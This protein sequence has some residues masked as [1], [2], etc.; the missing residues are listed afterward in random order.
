[1]VRL[2]ILA[3][4]AGSNARNILQHF[5]ESE[6]VQV[7]LIATNNPNAGVLDIAKE[8]GVESV[9]FDKKTF[10]ESDS[11]LH[12]LKESKVDFVVL[13]GFLWK[14]PEHVITAFPDRIINIHPA[15]LPKFGGKGMYGHHVHQAVYDAGE[16]E[17]GITIHYVNERYD[18]GKIIFQA[19][20]E[21]LP[22][23]G[24]KEIEAGVRAL[25]MEHFPLV[26]SSLFEK[27]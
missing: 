11:F 7:V 1:M 21:I 17:S 25:E 6:S 9:V 20:F 12:V 23:Y 15:L 16:K 24:P 22:G 8:Y 3:S 26:L 4:G 19:K 13:A 5:K 10:L 2:A 14:V 18:E 27:M